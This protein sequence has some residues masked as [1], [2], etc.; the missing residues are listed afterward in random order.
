MG[1]EDFGADTACRMQTARNRLSARHV[2]A[3]GGAAFGCFGAGAFGRVAAIGF[4][5]SLGGQVALIL[6]RALA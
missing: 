3:H 2:V 5:L 1:Q 6:L 4:Y